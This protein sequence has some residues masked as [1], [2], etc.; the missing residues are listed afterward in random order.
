[1]TLP[2]SARAA[3]ARELVR[4]LQAR[5]AEG[6]GQVSARHG[7]ASSLER[8]QWRRDD[9]RHGGGDRYYAEYGPVFN[10]G[11]IN[12]SVVHY[13]DMP[14]KRLGSATALSTIIHPRHPL[15]PSVHMHISWTEMRDGS[16]YWRVMADL[17][18]AI[19]SEAHVER[20]EQ[21]LRE[22]GGDSFSE[23]QQ[24]GDRYFH[25]PA[26]DRH[27]G[28]SHF[29]LEGYATDDPVADLALARGVG[30]GVIDLYCELLGEVLSGGAP[31]EKADEATQLAYHTAYLLQVL[32]L[33]RGTTSGLLVHDQNDLGIMGSLPS[34]VDRNLLAS[35]RLRLP[36]L[37]RPL[38]EALVDVLPDSTPS[39]VTNDVRLALAAAV[40]AFYRAQPE[41]LEL[42]ASGGR[43]PPT[44]ANHGPS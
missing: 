13:D 40:R 11:A 25:I 2:A 19:P 20:F 12:V 1:M 32:T 38:L 4:S 29:Y 37:Q 17:N 33:D 8:A 36:E 41:A 39:R 21:L 10:R 43:V 23:G 42:Q 7:G 27:R 14:D 18:P 28:V 35:W 26:L 44:V 15:A 3:Q 6:L 16:G 34:F 31:V 9:G 5:F 24:A 22:R 30:E